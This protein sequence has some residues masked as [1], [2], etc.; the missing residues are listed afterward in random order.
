[1]HEK[2]LPQAGE[3]QHRDRNR[4]RHRNRD[5]LPAIDDSDCD[6]DCDPDTDPD[7]IGFSL[8]IS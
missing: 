4:N 2:V 3:Y 6:W 5:C 1:M 7:V 8:L